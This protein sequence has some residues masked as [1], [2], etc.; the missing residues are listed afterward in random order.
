MGMKLENLRDI[1]WESHWD[2][3]LELMWDTLI[4]FQ[5]GRFLADLKDLHCEI[6]LCQMVERRY[7]PPVEGK[8]LMDMSSL[9]DKNWES[10]R[11]QKLT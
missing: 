2:H 11:D 1:Y 7:N 8:V 10:Q 9:V 4:E 3:K 5:V 6:H